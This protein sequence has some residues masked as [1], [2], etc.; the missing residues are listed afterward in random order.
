MADN[1]SRKGVGHQDIV[2]LINPWYKNSAW[3]V[4]AG[5]GD[6]HVVIP[7]KFLRELRQLP[8][9]VLN[10]P[11]ALAAQLETKYVGLDP[12][13]KSMVHAVKSDLTPALAR[14]NATIMDEVDVSINK[15]IPPAEDWTR[16]NVYNSIAQIVAQVSGRVFVGPE[17]CHEPE[18]LDAALNYT[19]EVINAHAAIKKMHPML[20][21]LFAS[22]LPEVKKIRERERRAANF[23]EPLLRQRLYAEEN[24]PTYKKPSDAMQWMMDRT[25]RKNGSLDIAKVAKDQLQLSFAAVHTTTATGTNILYTLATTPEYIAPLREEIRTVLAKHDG[26]LTSTA[27]GQLEKLDSYMKEVI[28]FYQMETGSFGRKVLKGITLSNGQ[29]IPPG[30]VIEAPVNAI[31]QDSELWPDAHKFDGFRHY[32]LRHSGKGDATVQARNLFVTTN[33]TNLMFGYGARACPGRFFAANEIKMIMARLILN[34]DIKMP[35]GLTERYQ[36][37]RLGRSSSPDPTKDLLI[38]RVQY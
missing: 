28:R 8:D 29:Y 23:F 37:F 9:D 22:R 7:T 15:Y 14:L 32:K 18:Y 35:D 30:V 10:M 13:L 34:F 25:E 4:A 38:K 27:L 12:D 21:S 16:I 1:L 3:R 5:D 31:Y 26:V 24:D 17:L 6:N 36:Q 2:L 19:M 20:K 33:E 11:Q